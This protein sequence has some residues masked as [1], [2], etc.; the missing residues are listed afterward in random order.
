MTSEQMF[1]EREAV[2]IYFCKFRE[3]E[4]S[5]KF[6]KLSKELRIFI[7]LCINSSQM[8]SSIVGS[9][10]ISADSVHIQTFGKRKFTFNLM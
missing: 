6:Q 3:L 7:F 2:I 5:S 8:Q 1:E 10:P 4:F 9:P